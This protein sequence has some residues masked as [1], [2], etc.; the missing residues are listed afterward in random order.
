MPRGKGGLGMNWE[1]GPDVCTLLHYIKIIANENRLYNAGNA[2]QC[3]AI[4]RHSAT[5][6]FVDY[7]VGKIP[8]RR[9]WQP[10]HYSCLGNPTDKGAWRATVCGV[11]K[12]GRDLVAK[13]QTT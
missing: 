4:F 9:K 13:P 2:F 3:I 10:F 6:H 1:I 7:R 12:V 5:E 11:A 8:W